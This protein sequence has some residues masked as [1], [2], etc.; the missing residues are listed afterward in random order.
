M[1]SKAEDFVCLA[2]LIICH[3]VVVKHQVTYVMQLIIST[4]YEAG[5]H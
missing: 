5:V 2:T 4:V 3:H 1:P